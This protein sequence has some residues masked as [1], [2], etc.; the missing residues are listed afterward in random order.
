MMD[1][2]DPLDQD[3]I[4]QAILGYQSQGEPVPPREPPP[5]HVQEQQARGAGGD[6]RPPKSGRVAQLTDALRTLDQIEASLERTYL[7]KGWLDRGAASVIYGESNVGK[8]FLALDVAMHVASGQDWHGHRVARGAGAVVYIAGEGGARIKNRVEAIR[9]ARPHLTKGADFI[10]LPTTLDL[11]TSEDAD[12]L[13]DVLEALG[14]PIALIIVD[15]LARAMGG[16][17]ENAAKDMG[18]FVR[19]IDHLRSVTG[20]HVSVIHHSG[21]D[22]A[23]GSRGHSSLRG[24]VDTEIELT[25][26]GQI[27]TAETKK[28]RDHATDGILSYQLEEVFLGKDEDGDQ[29]TSR[30]VAVT[31]APVKR[32]PKLTG[33]PLI[34]LQAFGDAL[35]HFGEVRSGD[36]FPP[37][38]Q[39]VSLE[40]WREYCDRHSLSSGETTTAKRTAFFK[41]K[42]KLQEKGLIRVVDGYAWRVAE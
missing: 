38:Q 35:A 6:S 12:C 39:C 20:A 10:L 1:G 8:T 27:V 26:E 37:G 17:D 33:Q 13:A 28:Q 4:R 30:V 5:L 25:R 31:E 24:A 14:R 2:G 9:L 40:R 7:V 29:V 41:A 23:K 16:G 32:A 21:K 22:T 36:M 3:Y 19:S 34:A 15:T 18:A 42:D 11:C